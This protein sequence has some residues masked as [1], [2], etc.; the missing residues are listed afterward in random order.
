MGDFCKRKKIKDTKLYFVGW[1]GG[2]VGNHAQIFTYNPRNDFSMLIDPTIG[3][4]AITDYNH[5][6][7]GKKVSVNNIFSFL[8]R[9]ELVDFSRKIEKA[10][11]NGQYKP[12]DFLYCFDDIDTFRIPLWPT[13]GAI[14]QKNELLKEFSKAQN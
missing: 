2:A 3:L 12:S 11:L 4:I 7:S 10:L 13:F 8:S 1:H 6:A 14:L 9:N 5:V